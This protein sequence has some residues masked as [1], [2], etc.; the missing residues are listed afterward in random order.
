MNVR[1]GSLI[2]VISIL[3]GLF[4]VFGNGSAFASQLNIPCGSGTYDIV[5]GVATR[6]STCTGVVDLAASG[7]PVVNEIGNA[8]FQESQITSILIP[9]TVTT[10]GDFAFAFSRISS[11]VIPNSVISIGVQG[12][13]N[14]RITSIDIPNSVTSLGSSAFLRTMDLET[15]SLGSGITRISDDLFSASGI[16]RIIIPSTV[17][18]IGT[19]AFEDCEHLESVTFASDSHLTTI[20]DAAFAGNISLMAIDIPESVEVIGLDVFPSNLRENGGLSINIK[21]S[22][23]MNERSY[24]FFDCL[25]S[26][27]CNE[28]PFDFSVTTGRPPGF[29]WGRMSYLYWGERRHLVGIPIEPFQRSVTYGL[30]RINWNITNAAISHSVTF[31]GN[32]GAGSMNVETSTVSA[33][34]FLNTFT[35][36]GYSFA[37]WANSSGGA[38]IYADQASYDF[39]GDLNLYAQWTLNPPPPVVYIPPP[40][41]PYLTVNI[42]PTIHG[43]SEIAICSAGEYDY[44]IVY[45]DGTPNS[46]LKN[47][48]FDSYTHKFFIDG[49]EV[50]D[51][52]STSNLKSKSISLSSLHLTGL[53]TCQIEVARGGVSIV[54]STTQNAQGVSEAASQ[55]KAGIEAATLEFQ[56]NL[57]INSESKKA[58]LHKNREIWR[59][60]VDQA[61]AV[62]IASKLA[63]KNSKEVI[64]ASR[65]Q[66]LS[67]SNAAK[68][69][70]SGINE[71]GSQ[72]IK[73]NGFALS[74]FNRESEYL[75]SVY[76]DKLELVGYGVSLKN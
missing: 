53:L 42:P 12:F 7:L 37:G 13:F 30:L 39:V 29:S 71:I 27:D 40:P 75:N 4:T 49:V 44:G 25:E 1:R 73:N 33:A 19:S 69:Y 64:Q 62:F 18:E 3:A 63:A 8:A 66:A 68:A 10:I 28:D 32:G 58:A 17:T 61:K 35:R 57:S 15:V 5:S 60:L 20:G 36:T 74:N 34:L 47:V 72:Y 50:K 22:A 16:Q 65:L 31:F 56:N 2:A 45:F 6:G 11:I 24:W 59:D 26:N 46:I 9:S 52:I 67:I 76:T 21:I 23:P 43:N 38:V 51:L 14:S 41:Q 55:L 54:S 48:P 70:K